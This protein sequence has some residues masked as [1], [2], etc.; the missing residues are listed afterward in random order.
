MG[1]TN[2]LATVEGKEITQ[3]DL[4]AFLKAL[5]P[6]VASQFLTGSNKELLD[7]LINQEL[8]Y[9][10]AKERG[11]DKEEEYK[12]ELEKIN[13]NFLK[14]YAIFKHLNSI[15]VSEDEVLAYYTENKS[16][17]DASENIRASHILV[18]SESLAKEVLQK[19]SAG[20]S[21]E[22]AAQQYSDCPSKMQGGD[23]G[24]FER[25]RMVPEFDEA[26]FAME[27]GEVSS[28]VRTQFG[29]H[30]IKLTDKMPPHQQSFDE[31]KTSLTQQLMS[32]KQQ[33]AYYN[34]IDALKKK[35]EVKINS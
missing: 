12:T 23:L 35:Y 21:F 28:P 29:F 14:Q 24:Y 15:A 3:A 8:Y 4:D 6:K 22:D 1:K 16:L 9:L 18:E 5:D 2:V 34:K 27:K 11:I 17:F 26:V 7:E 10:D 19:M 13:Q 30:I 20:L 32:L 25:G 33:D 31:V